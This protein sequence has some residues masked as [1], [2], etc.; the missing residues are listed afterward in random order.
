MLIA[1]YTTNTQEWIKMYKSLL[2]QTGLEFSLIL[3]HTKADIFFCS[4]YDINTI[5]KLKRQNPHMIFV[6]ISGEPTPVKC[7]ITLLFDCKNVPS[8]R[9]SY[10]PTAYFPFYAASFFHRNNHTPDALIKP[11]PPGKYVTLSKH[12]FCAYMYRYDLPHRTQICEALN[13]YKPVSIL[14]KSKNQTTNIKPIGGNPYDDAVEIYKPFKFV[15]CAENHALP[16]YITEKIIN[17]MLAGAIPIYWGAPDVVKHFNP[18]SFIRVQEEKSLDDLVQKVKKIDTNP[19]LYQQM[20]AEPWLHDNKLNSFLQLNSQMAH[21]GSL[22][23]SHIKSTKTNGD[24]NNRNFIAKLSHRFPKLMSRSSSPPPPPKS[25]PIPHPTYSRPSTL[26]LLLH[27]TTH[28]SNQQSS[29]V[30]KA[31]K[32]HST[33][34]TN[35]TNTTRSTERQLITRTSSSLPFVSSQKMITTKE[36]QTYRRDVRSPRKGPYGARAKKRFDIYLGRRRTRSPE[37]L[38]RNRQEEI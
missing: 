15:I 13:K 30:L 7:R 12:R 6:F 18:K 23:L 32:V 8:L 37:R 31:T 2:Q 27:S 36:R 26:T 1:T 34:T 33:N 10:V 20:L 21:Y 4:Y 3:N 29:D 17:A 38:N 19:E 28:D 11:T 24:H 14:G 5:N 16:G 22:L 9:P 35:T 25:Y